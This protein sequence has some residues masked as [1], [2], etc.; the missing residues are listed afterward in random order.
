ME[1][2]ILK[3]EI[4]TDPLKL[5]YAAYVANGNH[6]AIADLGNNTSRILTRD[7]SVDSLLM[8]IAQTG[9]ISRLEKAK[10]HPNEAISAP[11]LAVFEMI[12]S[13]FATPL[14]VN[15]PRVQG[16]V[17]AL[18]AG[19]TITAA[20]KDGFIALSQVLG[21]R[22]EELLGQNISHHDVAMALNT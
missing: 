15:D 16:M 8:Y 9:I 3:N 20:E 7:I 19:G 2:I 1:Y 6:S 13:P 17:A 14:N 5:G 12:R 10:T 18:V 22:F 11:A 4:L 21:S